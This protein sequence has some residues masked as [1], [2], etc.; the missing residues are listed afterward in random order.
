MS[1]AAERVGGIEIVEEN[2]PVVRYFV[3]G[4]SVGRCG[5]RDGRAGY[6]GT[7]GHDHAST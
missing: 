1:L 4:P 5:N 3:V 7:G 6:R 2:N